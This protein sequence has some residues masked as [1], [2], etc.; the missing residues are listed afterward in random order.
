MQSRV[1]NAVA[2]VEGCF[3]AALGVVFLKSSLLVAGGTTG[4]A[5]IIDG[6]FDQLGFGPLFFLV[7]LPFYWLGWRMLGVGFLLRTTFCVGLVSVMVELLVSL[8]TLSVPY[9]GL[10]AVISAVLIAFG[11]VLILRAG[12]SLGGVNIL[13]LCLHK[14]YGIP[15]AR[16]IL[17]ADLLIMAAAL[18]LY[19]WETV[20]WS[21]LCT[22]LLGLILGRHYRPAAP[23]SGS[24]QAA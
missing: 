11:L 13:G 6:V 15:A 9:A 3:L 7:N 8:V 14:R 4:I 20:L 16:V 17:L 12:G 19:G 21:A 10:T 22:T 18:L 1:V 24:Q 5:L 2:L 23:I